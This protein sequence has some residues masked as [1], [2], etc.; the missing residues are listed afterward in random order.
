MHDQAAAWGR[1]RAVLAVAGMPWDALDDGVQQ[2]RIKLLEQQAD[3]AR[4]SVR[5]PS[6]WTAVVATRVAMDWHRSRDRDSD[7]RR[8]L[9]DH[10]SRRPPPEHSEEEQVLALAV[11][12]GL[13]RLPEEQRQL[14]VLRFYVDLSVSEI[15][16][17]LGLPDGTVKSRL[18]RAVAAMRITLV[19]REVI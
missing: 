17:I 12:E 15:A 10:W 13:G 5:N 4:Q 8:R 16:Q 9:A 19:D 14:L 18:H 2:V 7:L 1:V 11:A 3:P 6:A